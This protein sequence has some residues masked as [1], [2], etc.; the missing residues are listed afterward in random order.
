[1]KKLQSGFDLSYVYYSASDTV[2]T[3]TLELTWAQLEARLW[4]MIQVS[5][6]IKPYACAIYFNLDGKQTFKSTSIS[7][8]DLNNQDNAGVCAGVLFE[9][10]DNGFV[11]LEG[12]GG[13]KDGVKVYF[14]KR[15]HY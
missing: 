6:R 15:F 8:Q 2:T 10:P 3:Q 1:M 9:M 14:G 12:T 5:E 7:Q 13:A 4:L 11:G